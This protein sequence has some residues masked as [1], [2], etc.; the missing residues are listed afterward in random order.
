[1]QRLEEVYNLRKEVGDRRDHGETG[2]LIRGGISILRQQVTWG[3]GGADTGNVA[4]NSGDV[5]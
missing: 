1:M 4:T 5:K 2:I 3:G